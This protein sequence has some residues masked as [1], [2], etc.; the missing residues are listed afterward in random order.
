LGSEQVAK[1]LLMHKA[2]AFSRLI[3]FGLMIKASFFMIDLLL[4]AAVVT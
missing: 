3:F 4:L 1:R 2:L